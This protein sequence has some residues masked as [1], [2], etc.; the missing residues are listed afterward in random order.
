LQKH[1]KQ[2]TILPSKS[3]EQ[4]WLL[5]PYFSGPLCLSQIGYVVNFN[6]GKH[7]KVLPNQPFSN[8]SQRRQITAAQ[9]L[10]KSSKWQVMTEYKASSSMSQ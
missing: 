4:T 5:F 10:R 3:Q 6:L 9:Y 8:V 1:L 2:I 7:C